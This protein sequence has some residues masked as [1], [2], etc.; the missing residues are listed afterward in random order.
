MAP[1][2]IFFFP[3]GIFCI[4]T[5]RTVQSLHDLIAHCCL[6]TRCSSGNSNQKR[7]GPV[8]PTSTALRCA[9]RTS[10]WGQ[11]A[12]GLGV[13]PVQGWLGLPPQR[14]HLDFHLLPPVGLARSVF[15]HG[16]RYFGS[17]PKRSQRYYRARLVA[18]RGVVPGA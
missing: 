9:G 1:H 12:A 16:Y 15:C 2:G 11:D 3:S 14:T 4:P 7:L 17:Q 8:L 10:G 6:S 13:E 5:Q 18:Q